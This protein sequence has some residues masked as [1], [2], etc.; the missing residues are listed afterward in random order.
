[1]AEQGAYGNGLGKAFRLSDVPVLM[2]QTLRKTQLAV[3]QI[4]Y[5]GVDFGSTM[6][7]PTEDAYLVALQV[8]EC[9][10]HGLSV[11]GGE[12][13]CVPIVP[14]DTMIYDLRQNPIARIASP[15]HS[16]HFYLP[17]RALDEIAD[18]F[19][20]PHVDDL[21]FRHGDCMKDPVVAHLLYSLLPALA[22]PHEVCSLFANHVAM[23]LR[24]HVA[25]TYGQMQ[26]A[27]RP[28][29]GG[30]M[31]WQERR[32]RELLEA[33][34]DGE[35]TLARLAE[36]CRLSVS[37]FARAFRQS[38]GTSPHRWL[39]QRRTDKAK[40]LLKIRSLSL[41]EI[42]LACGFA[43]QSHFTRVFTKLTGTAPG[44]MRRLLNN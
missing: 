13:P 24:A 22:K 41:A 26:L 7:I 8:R 35:V 1:M 16:L 29:R 14:G 39:L 30:L 34:L 17:R 44:A 23:A 28:V 32:V 42:A 20:A 25:H 10:D 11:N 6:P 19:D 37:H 43:D 21:R 12:V 3:T 18:E 33:N 15:F 36:E 38:T 5:D 31:A 4:R 2:T 40:E 9:P 27:Q